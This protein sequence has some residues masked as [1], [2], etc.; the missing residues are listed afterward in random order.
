MEKQTF[1][2]ELGTQYLNV[3]KTDENNSMH[4]PEIPSLLIKRQRKRT[5]GRTVL[6]KEVGGW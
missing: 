5:G 4:F 2:F 1:S 3:I 6:D